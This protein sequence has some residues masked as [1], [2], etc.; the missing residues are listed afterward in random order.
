M[1]LEA[2]SAKVAR[3]SL[4]MPK[5]IATWFG[6]L[7]IVVMLVN[8][9]LDVS[10]RNIMNTPIQGTLEYITYWYMIAISFI[11]MWLAQDRREH[12]SVTLLT[13][14]LSKQAQVLMTI[15]STTLSV[16]FLV[17][18]TWFGM[19]QALHYAQI[20]EY[21]GA[22][23]VP[24]WPFRFLVPACFIGLIVALLVTARSDIKSKLQRA[25]STPLEQ[26]GSK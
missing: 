22:S 18:L 20:G 14:H 24:I 6:M 5:R 25:R 1:A 8:V 26:G 19:E 23:R 17:G 12:I 3:P 4:A 11:G 2:S 10:L 9:V 7:A 21:V 15:F 16:G 13:D